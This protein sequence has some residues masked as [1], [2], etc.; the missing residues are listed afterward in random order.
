MT[1]VRD[2]PTSIRVSWN[3]PSSLTG[4]TGYRISYRTDDNSDIM[5]VGV[6]T[7]LILSGLTNGEIY[8]I[9]IGATSMTLNSPNVET[10]VRL[11]KILLT[12]QGLCHCKKNLVFNSSVRS[13]S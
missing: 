9:S 10:T 8:T 11:G 3:H 6:V 1:A 2:G 5:N 13:T 4:I 7:S 12:F